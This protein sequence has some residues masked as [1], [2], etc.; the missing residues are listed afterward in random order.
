MRD[1]AEGELLGRYRIV[2]RLG[3][4]GMGTTYEAE[5]KGSGAR[6]A[7]KELRLA[8]V[9]DW[10]VLE[11]FEREARVLANVT[12]PAVPA[13]VDHF[14]SQTPDGPTFCLVQE[15]APG[16]SLAECILDRSP[17]AISTRTVG[18]TWF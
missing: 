14:S 5:A 12:H 2:R 7:L 1:R 11:L 4:G 16:R 13:Y 6:F 3:R 15:L 18:S 9:D 17:R 10:K 8:Q